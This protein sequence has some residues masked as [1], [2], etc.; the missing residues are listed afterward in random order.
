M[1][2][3]YTNTT[4][5]LLIT[6]TNSDSSNLVAVLPGNS[7]YVE[8][9]KKQYVAPQ[10]TLSS[11]IYSLE[12]DIKTDL[13]ESFK[14]TI[15]TTK[16]NFMKLTERV[17]KVLNTF[18]ENEDQFTALDVSNAVKVDGGQFFTHD[19]IN[20]IIKPIME[21][22]LDVQGE[23][24]V[25][26]IEVS[27]KNGPAKARLYSPWAKLP[28]DYN[29]TKSVAISPIA[30]AVP[31]VQPSAKVTG[32][33]SNTI[34]AF[35]Q[36]ASS[37]VKVK[38][39]KDGAIELPKQFLEQEGFLASYASLNIHPNSIS[40]DFSTPVSNIFVDVGTRIRKTT[41]VQAN[42]VG[43]DC[44]WIAAYKGKLVIAKA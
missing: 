29:K 21:L 26:V 36:K 42:L 7:V 22:I 38:V 8:E 43:A 33:I 39:R 17:T 6:Q 15:L 24:V 2:L 5:R 25:D 31:T 3:K 32:L 14:K 44:L 13:Q 41:L 11:D 19:E 35:C 23:Y 16:E 20:E 1:I 28:S 4:K 27:T 40:L 9:S 34:P 10:L 30:K 18:I 12:S 37:H